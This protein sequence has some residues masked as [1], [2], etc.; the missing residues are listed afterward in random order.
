VQS[1]LP[2][3]EVVHDAV[4]EGGAHSSEGNPAGAKGLYLSRAFME[5]GTA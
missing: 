4:Q 3:P 1:V 2:T 5:R